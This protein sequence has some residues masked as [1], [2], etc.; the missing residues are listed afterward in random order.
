MQQTTH[1]NPFTIN[2]E[3]IDMFLEHFRKKGRGASTLDSYRRVLEKLC[4]N[5]PD[6]GILDSDSLA[7]WREALE[8]EDCSIQTKNVR[9]AAVNSYASFYG[10]NDLRLLP[11]RNHTSEEPEELTR[12]EYLRLLQTAKLHENE[13]LYLLV[14]TLCVTGSLLQDLPD[15]TVEALRRQAASNMDSALSRMPVFLGDELLDYA[16]RQNIT[17]G[18]VFVTRNGRPLERNNVYSSIRK[19][20]HDAQVSEKKANPLCLRKLYQSTQASILE[21]LQELIRRQYDQ[22]LEKEEQTVGG[23]A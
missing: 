11:F 10:R 21:G 12:E 6:P 8:K 7:S 22:L 17:S 1:A 13:R 4:H 18:P 2:Q 19:L 5:F 14:K 23:K 15:I 3:K 16:R 20:C 9:I